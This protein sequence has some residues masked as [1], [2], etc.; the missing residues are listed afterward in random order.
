MTYDQKE[1]SNNKIDDDNSECRPDIGITIFHANPDAVLGKTFYG[2]TDQKPAAYNG[3]IS[4]QRV[5]DKRGY[6]MPM[7][8][9]KYCSCTT[10]AGTI[11]TCDAL[12]N[13]G[14]H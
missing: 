9:R 3:G 7:Q 1:I 2:L 13:A 6:D 14:R 12:Q 4:N 8:E 11:K 5:A 10:A